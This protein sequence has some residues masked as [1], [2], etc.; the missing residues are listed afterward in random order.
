MPRSWRLRDV[1]A[2]R[3]SGG[4]EEGCCQLRDGGNDKGKEEELLEA[5]RRVCAE[6]EDSAPYVSGIRSTLIKLAKTAD[7]ALAERAYEV[8]AACAV[9]ASVCEPPPPD[10][11]ALDEAA[12]V[13]VRR[14]PSR[15]R[16]QRDTGFVLWP[17]AL[18]LAR[19][20]RDNAHLVRDRVVLELGAGAGLSGIA[21]AAL[22]KK[23]VLTDSNDECLRN[24]AYNA[25]LNDLGEASV[26]VRHLDFADPP[27]TQYDRIIASD[28]VC[29]DGDARALAAALAALLSSDGVALVAQPNPRH[30][31][32]VDKFPDALAAH[33]LHFTVVSTNAYPALT[34][35]LD[36]DERGYSEWFVYHITRRRS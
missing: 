32:G 7:E 13:L 29:C 22:A 20:V 31:Y 30:R 27:A 2:F 19:Y 4:V 1:V 26:A 3:V 12:S 16:Q 11:V 35:G 6:D 9:T 5:L 8:L 36:D 21:C 25:R 18:V 34:L 15:Q 24:L 17:A 28:V 33:H 23:V 10:E 14:V